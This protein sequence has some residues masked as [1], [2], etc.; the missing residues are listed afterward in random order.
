MDLFEGG[1]VGKIHQISIDREASFVV[2]VSLSHNGPMNLGAKEGTHRLKLLVFG[3]L[4]TSG[5]VH[6]PRCV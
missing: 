3:R 2:K 6:F 4:I 5:C 1:D